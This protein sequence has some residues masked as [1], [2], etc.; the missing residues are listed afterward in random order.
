[1]CVVAGAA[2]ACNS[3]SIGVFDSNK[4]SLFLKYA[5]IVLMIGRQM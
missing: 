2:M 3:V 5:K 1:M 4:R